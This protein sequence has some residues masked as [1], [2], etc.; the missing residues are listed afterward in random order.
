MK[1][2]I[3]IVGR[4]NVGKSTLFNQLTRS[5][6]A[7]V[8]DFSGLTRDRQYGEGT[9]DERKFI[10]I[11]TGGLGEADDS[12]D[13]LMVNQSLVAISEADI[14]LFIVD[15]KA[16]V[17]PADLA[18][19]KHLR[20]LE[21]KRIYLVANKSDGVDTQL[22][23]AEFYQLGLGEPM[24]IAA[25]HNRGVKQ[26]IAYVLDQLPKTDEI[27][28]E[29]APPGTKIAVLGRP[30]VGKSTL[31]NRMLG[32]DRVVVFDM[33]GTTRDSIYIPYERQGKHYTLIDTAGIRRRGKINEQ[34]EKFSVI[35]AL[36]A[37]DDA[38]VVLLVLDAKEGIVDQDLHLLGFALERGRAIVIALNKWDG[39]E[40]HHKEHVKSEIKRRLQFVSFAKIHTISALHGTGVGDLYG[41][42]DKA[43]AS[44]QVRVS[45]SQLTRF[46]EDAI[47]AH[48]PPTVNGRR[49]KLRYAHFGGSNPPTIIIHGNQTE[50]VDESYRRYLENSFR[51]ALKIIGTPIK[52]IFKTS[53]NPYSDGA[54]KSTSRP[55]SPKKFRGSRGSK[56]S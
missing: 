7:L 53:D 9:I 5:R 20:S 13:S 41:S 10:V 2:V 43:Y 6:D 40:T 34:V 42:I 45:A 48:Q 3:A 16:G 46:L 22:A 12:V 26:L 44:G 55:A 38:D 50:H 32:E 15:S 51:Q 23:L 36:Q 27:T 54:S 24:A 19:T 39:L 21:G 25:A 18:I 17:M 30:N 37:I 28:E 14:V 4:P 49:I 33:P 29:E 11:D 56:D 1:P 8:A 47:A 35:K 52:I 31:V